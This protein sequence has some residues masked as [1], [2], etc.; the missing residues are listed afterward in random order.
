MLV[1]P[2]LE[3]EKGGSRVP[4]QAASH[5]RPHFQTAIP[6]AILN[7]EKSIYLF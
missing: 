4:G 7:W 5:R 3:A 6:V 2:T 1:I